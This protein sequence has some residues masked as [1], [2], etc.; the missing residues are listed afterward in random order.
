MRQQQTGVRLRARAATQQW[1][2]AAPPLPVLGARAQGRTPA[3]SRSSL[4]LSHALEG[5]PPL[6]TGSLECHTTCSVLAFTIAAPLLVPYTLS[7]PVRLLASRQRPRVAGGDAG[8]ERGCQ[9]L[10][11]N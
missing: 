3:C 1:R 10:I 11:E 6:Y 2:A 5:H 4:G 8:F 9:K 7:A